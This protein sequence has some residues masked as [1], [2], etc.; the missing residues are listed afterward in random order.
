M[1]HLY[2]NDKI[3]FYIGDV[4]DSRVSAMRFRSR[5]GLSC[6]GPETGPSCEF[7]PLEAVKTNVSAPKTF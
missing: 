1:R 6:R 5:S 3:K 4:R 7:F 2:N